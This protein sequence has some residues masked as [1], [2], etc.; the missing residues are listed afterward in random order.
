MRKNNV[1][2]VDMESAAIAEVCKLNNTELV[3]IKGISDFPGHYEVDD[4][5][6]YQEFVENV[7]KV[8]EKI[9]NDYITDF[10]YEQG[11]VND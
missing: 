3:I 6:Q 2:I 7:P 9:L 1:D 4:E 11:E 10:I 8:M 5:R